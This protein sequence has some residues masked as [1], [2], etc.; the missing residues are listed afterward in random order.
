MSGELKA[1]DRVDELLKEAVEQ[2]KRDITYRE[3]VIDGT[4]REI[5]QLRRRV[6]ELEAELKQERAK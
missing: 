1:P 6:K 2:H 5:V 4:H 3:Q